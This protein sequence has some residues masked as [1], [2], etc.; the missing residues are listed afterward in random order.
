MLQEAFDGVIIT[1]VKQRTGSKLDKS[2]GVRRK[3]ENK[4]ILSLS[5]FIVKP[6]L[7]G[8]ITRIYYLNRELSYNNRLLL[9]S[10]GGNNAATVDFP[11]RSILNRGTRAAQIFSPSLIQKA[12]R[13]I[14]S[15]QVN[16]IFANHL[17][18][19]LH[20][21]V[22]S[23]L[24]SVPLIFDD[25]NVEYIR[26]RRVNSP[27]WPTIW[28]VEKLVCSGAQ[29][30]LCV[31]DVDQSLLTRGIK[32][33]AE[34]VQVVENGVDTTDLVTREVDSIACREQLGILK[35]DLLFLFYGSFTYR[36]NRIAAQL[37][38]D[39]ILPRLDKFGRQ[40]K[41]LF[42]GRG[43]PLISQGTRVGRIS[44]EWLGFVDDLVRYIKSANVV[45][46]PLTAG[47]GT[48][49]K[50]LESIACGRPVVTTPIGA[51]GLDRRVC[52][53]FLQICDNWDTFAKMTLMVAQRIQ[54]SLS[55]EFMAKYDW[56]RIVERIEL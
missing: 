30:V 13:L 12:L 10:R 2:I 45:L 48:R 35:D 55:P 15:E 53:P 56:G 21:L 32:L 16:L 47:S 8:S 5:P 23:R 51:E 26:F 1:I 14:K 42:I 43:E 3:I 6:F 50:I 11:T 22:L 46:A 4:V 36:P 19:G 9:V 17:W 41:M 27:L 44:V 40:G 34:K 52:G 18:T 29:K 33:N 31:S 24:S 38:L 37:I 25:H 20:G 54:P 28:A 49:F 7:H 39:Q